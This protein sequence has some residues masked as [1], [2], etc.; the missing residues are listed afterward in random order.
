MTAQYSSN[1]PYYTTDQSSGYLA[2]LSYRSIPSYADDIL[3]T[4]DQ[5]YQHRPDL[6]AYNL[7]GDVDLWW[8]FAVRNPDVI[9]DPV[10]DLVAGVQIYLPKQ[11]T[12][13]SALGG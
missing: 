3:Y 5:T 2:T 9:Q 12:L 11:S 10:Y 4:V 1:S 13:N 7:Y 6:L 8:V